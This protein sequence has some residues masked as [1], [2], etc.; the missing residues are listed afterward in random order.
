MTPETRKRRR[1]ESISPYSWRKSLKR[2]NSKEDSKEDIVEGLSPKQKNL[3]KHKSIGKARLVK[4][5][6]FID[7]KGLLQFRVCPTLRRSQMEKIDSSAADRHIEHARMEQMNPPFNRS[8]LPQESPKYEYLINVN[9][10]DEE[11]Y[12]E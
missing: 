11:N 2:N 8:S 6:S 3:V 1:R 4:L 5:R 9:F 10:L 7:R 12:G